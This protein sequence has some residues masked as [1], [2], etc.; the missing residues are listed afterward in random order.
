VVSVT[1]PYGRI[2]RFLDTRHYSH[3]KNLDSKFKFCVYITCR[4]H[5]GTVVPNTP[6]ATSSVSSHQPESRAMVSTNGCNNQASETS[7]P[8]EIGEPPSLLQLGTRPDT[9]TCLTSLSRDPLLT[10]LRISTGNRPHGST[11]VTSQGHV[12]SRDYAISSYSTGNVVQ[13]PWRNLKTNQL[14]VKK[15]EH[16]SSYFT[17]RCL[18][19]YDWFGLHL[20]RRLTW[21]KHIFTKRKQLGLTLKN[22]IGCSDESPNS[23]PTTNYYSIKPY[24]NPSGPTV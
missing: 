20:D 7:V 2:L 5:T 21:H 14:S 6:T 18:P 1:N 12:T 9:V 17:T 10:F 19:P 22:C 16:V 4:Y 13:D 24:S 15:G 3:K 8:F 23:P 11:A